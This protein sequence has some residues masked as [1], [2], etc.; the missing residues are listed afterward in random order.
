MRSFM[1]RGDR[2]DMPPSAHHVP[3]QNGPDGL[4]ISWTNHESHTNVLWL[5]YIFS[6]LIDNFQGPKRE[7]SEFRRIMET[8]W[9]HLDPES[10]ESV[11]PFA[12]ASDVVAYAVEAGWIAEGQLMGGVRDEA[13]KS[14]ISVL[15]WTGTAKTDLETSQIGE[16][17]LRRSPRKQLPM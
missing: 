1:I 16:T 8:F 17:P 11:P 4:P 5:A 9:V 10:D 13:E 6:Y 2:K 14:I 12:S 7:L 15:S 3:Y